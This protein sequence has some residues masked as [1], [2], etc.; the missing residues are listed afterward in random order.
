MA[1]EVIPRRA[2]F[3]WEG[4]ERS[5]LRQQSIETFKILNPS[6]EILVIDGSGIPIPGDS[7]LERV[8]RSDWARYRKLHEVG[9]VYFDTDIVF[10]R[11]IPDEWLEKDM[12]L[13]LGERIIEHVAALGCQK[14][15]PWFQLVDK[16]CGQAFGAGGVFNYQFFGVHMLNRLAHGLQG[17][18]TYWLTPE[19]FLQVPWDLTERLWQDGGV[20]SPFAIGVHWFG[21]DWLALSMEPKVNQAWAKESNC[22]VAKAIRM[23]QA[24]SEAGKHREQL[25]V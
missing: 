14:D 3:F 22:L 6:W 5:W 11:P 13:S 19:T 18:K 17:K 9:G 7:T 15:E 16:A 12:I 23:A 24:S 2:I 1:G 20:V 25:G 8:L 10:C 21:G 4:P